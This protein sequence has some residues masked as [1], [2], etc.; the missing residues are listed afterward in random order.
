MRAADIRQDGLFSCVSLEPRIPKPHPLRTILSLLDE[1]LAALPA[2][3][4][5]TC[6]E[7][8]RPSIAPEKLI[9]TALLRVC[10][11]TRSKRLL[12]AQIGYN[13]LFRWFVGLS[14]G[15]KAWGPVVFTHNHAPLLQATIAHKLFAGVLGQARRR[16]LNSSEH[17]SIDGTLIEAWAS[18]KRFHR[19]D[20]LPPP[21]GLGR[22]GEVD[23]LGE[24]RAN[25]TYDS[26]TDPDCRL[27]RKAVGQSSKLCHVGHLLMENRSGFIVASAVASPSGMAERDVVEEFGLDLPKGAARRGNK[28]YGTAD[29]VEMLCWLDIIP[30][31]AQKD[32]S[33]TSA[34][35]ERTTHRPGYTVSLHIR[36]LIQARFGWMKFLCTIRNP[37]SAAPNTSMIRCS[38]TPWLSTCCTWP[39]C[40]IRRRCRPVTGVIRPLDR[41]SLARGRKIRGIR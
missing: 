1:G 34:I 16:G 38:S 15:G 22:N 28:C 4:D 20:V 40:C 11:S 3:F 21:S 19:K 36:K 13:L 10:D 6:S 12:M 24:S 35:Y 7:F 9:R 41:S 25:D 14:A 26:I 17:F 27:Y 31:A 39:T 32:T 33:Y 18:M 30:R 5:T 29:H 23:F 8:G 37:S 2:D